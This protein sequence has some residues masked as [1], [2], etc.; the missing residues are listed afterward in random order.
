[1]T[2]KLPLVSVG[3]RRAGS[4]ENIR[5]GPDLIK[6]P[7]KAALPK[8][9]RAVVPGGHPNATVMQGR[10]RWSLVPLWTIPQPPLEP[11]LS[12][13]LSTIMTLQ[14]FPCALVCVQ[15]PMQII[16]MK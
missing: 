1:M 4:F 6:L 11:L 9:L 15:V 13:A 7:K 16:S 14:T 12:I 8:W 2:N 5:Q 10:L 3:R